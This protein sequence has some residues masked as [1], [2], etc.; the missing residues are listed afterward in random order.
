MTAA[1]VAPTLPV[2]VNGLHD[3]ASKPALVF[4]NVSHW[5]GP[6]VAVN[7]VSCS[8]GQG[9]TG[10]LG[11]KGAGKSTLL[12]LAAGLSPPSSGTVSVFGES[13]SRGPR[14]YRD[15]ALVP[16]RESLPP[17]SIV[18]RSADGASPRAALNGLSAS[19]AV[20][21]RPRRQRSCMR[22]EVL[23]AARWKPCC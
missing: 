19:C 11:P 17:P 10:L 12:T 14:V 18:A 3:D 23:F 6:V 9:I 4:D 22:A 5:Y 16:E 21:V 2:N 8:V 20:P 7:D 15:V 1:A 13:P